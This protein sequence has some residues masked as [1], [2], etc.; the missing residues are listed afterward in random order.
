MDGKTKTL[1]LGLGN[2]LLSD[3]GVGLTIAAELKSRL[4]QS[5]ITV[6]ETSVAGL[7]LLDLLVGYDRAIIIDAIQTLNGKPGQIYRLDPE[8][9][10]T[11]RRTISPHDVN[12]TTALELGKKVGLS[13]P[14]EIVIFAIE[15]SDVSTFSEEC[16]PEIR[17]AIPTC[18]EMV[19]QELK[20]WW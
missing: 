6:M 12:F 9:F 16:T 10:D 15:V 20:R 13:L 1:I 14:Q 17:H 19:L 2:S 8:A 11:T 18:V 7:S 5:D 4:E 3:D